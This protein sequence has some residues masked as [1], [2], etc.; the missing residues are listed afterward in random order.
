MNLA[1]WWRSSNG[2]GSETNVV[3]IISAMNR[4]QDD[5]RTWEAK[6]A[7]LAKARSKFAIVKVTFP[8][9][10]EFNFEPFTDS[11]AT[12][13][14][15]FSCFSSFRLVHFF[16]SQMHDGIHLGFSYST[17]NI[18]VGRRRTDVAKMIQPH[19]L[20]RLFLAA[21]LSSHLIPSRVSK[22][23]KAIES[24]SSISKREFLTATDSTF[25]WEA[26]KKL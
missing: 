18:G 12:N 17:L 6:R 8:R 22:H 25:S 20:E 16:C 1:Y 5:G 2:F 23:Q 24:L 19:W 3:K 15:P 7:K 14:W 4:G 13:L 11:S 10:V 9:G 21:L 26:E